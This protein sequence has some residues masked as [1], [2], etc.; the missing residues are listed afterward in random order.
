[1]FG[2]NLFKWL[3]LAV[4]ILRLVGKI[5]GDEADKKQV[6]ESEARTVDSEKMDAC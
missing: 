1:M 3:N 4:Q 2:L 5:F 6:S